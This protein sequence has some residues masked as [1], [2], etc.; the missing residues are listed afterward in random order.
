MF[1]LGKCAQF[2]IGAEVLVTL[3][4]NST[5]FWD[6]THISLIEVSRRFEGTYWLHLHDRRDV[7]VACYF[8]VHSSASSSNLKIYI[9]CASE[10]S[11]IFYQITW[12][13]IQMIVLLMY[14]LYSK[15]EYTLGSG[16]L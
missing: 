13:H 7:L 6:V 12:Y 16:I 8:F 14:K 10:T 11:V 3:V 5:I 1:P 4:M 9:I 2:D 15:L